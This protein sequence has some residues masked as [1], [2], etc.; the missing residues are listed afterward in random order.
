MAVASTTEL[1]IFG[2]RLWQ[3]VLVAMVLGVAVGMVMG[4]DAEVFKRLGDLFMR[5]IKMVVPPLI[6]LAI[7]SGLTS[8]DNARECARVGTKGAGA[9]L[10]TGAFAV[11][12]G[13][14]AANIMDPGIGLK[15]DAASL[16]SSSAPLPAA[17]A[18]PEPQAMTPWHFVEMVVPDNIFKAAAESH[19]LHI[20]FFAIFTGICIMLAGA[21][22][23][24][25]RQ[26]IH[27][28]AAVAF[29]MIGLVVCLAPLAVFGFMAWTIGTYGFGFLVTLGRLVVTVLVACLIQYILFGVFI[30]VFARLK[31]MPFYRKLMAT[32]LMAFSTSSSKAT[33]ST[34]M[35]EL[36][37]KLGVSERSTN[38]LLPLGASM[39]M[40]G[41]AIYLGICAVFFAQ[42]YG[43][44][45][46]AHEY[47]LLLVTCTLG[48]IGAAGI[49]SGSIVFMSLVLGSVG[50][51][52]EGIG[53]I[54]GIDRLLDMVRTTVNI[55]GDSAI[56]LII[57]ATEGTI[58]KSVYYATSEELAAAA[59]AGQG[60]EQPLT[61]A[62]VTAA[63][64]T[65]VA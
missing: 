30:A 58:D 33:M 3:Q 27:S 31:P 47:L 19:Y 61:P 42:I 29:K 44:D 14:V 5:L 55:T 18:I 2:L 51:P 45:L 64:E 21:K 54:L 60:G 32:Q 48:S 17:G 37:H 20:V 57:D 22:A 49:P 65:N 13:L 34:A 36:Q 11:V 46:Q 39:N 15:V 9:Y 12:I 25:A 53:L 38:F 41:T 7:V 24:P 50:L 6:F 10:L 26:V 4:H 23:E 35:H 59:A 8:L 62:A 52:L 40:D 1:K 56:T 28:G 43:V 63:R 16:H